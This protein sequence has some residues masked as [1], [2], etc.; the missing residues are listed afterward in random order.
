MNAWQWSRVLH[1][2]GVVIWI[3]G[4]GFV[5]LVLLPAVRTL[6]DVANRHRL[7]ELAEGRFAWW[8]RGATLVTGLSGFYMLYLTDGWS[9]FTQ[10]GQW[11]LHAMVA[12]WAIFTLML[13]VLE[14][15]VLHRMFA[16]LAQRDPHGLMRRIQRMHVFLLV[17]SLITVAGAVAG[18]HGGNL[19]AW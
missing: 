7:F 19:L 5:T 18:S 13:F 17:I 1:V 9:R 11:W 14:P 2:L 8:A 12:V 15:L 10:S 16:R 6:P 3:G 4:V